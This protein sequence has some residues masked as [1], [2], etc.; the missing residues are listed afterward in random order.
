MS[1]TQKKTVVDGIIDIAAFKAASR[2]Q[3]SQDVYKTIRI[4][5][6]VFGEANNDNI[7]F[8]SDGF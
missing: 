3:M 6:V 4:I 8:P 7:I 1:A 5:R 2:F